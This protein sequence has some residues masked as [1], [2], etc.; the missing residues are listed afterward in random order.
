MSLP[1]KKIDSGFQFIVES[2]MRLFW[3]LFCFGLLRSE[4]FEKI[5]AFPNQSDA[6][7]KPIAT[8]SHAFSRAWRRL[9]VFALS[10]DWFLVLFSSV[11]IGQ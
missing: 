7:L 1:Q 9:R 5:A 4:W 8:W 3:S 11:V 6:K 10:F 2:N